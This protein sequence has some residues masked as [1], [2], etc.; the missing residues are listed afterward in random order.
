[1]NGKRQKKAL[2]VFLKF[3]EAGKVKTRLAAEIGPNEALRLY[4]ILARR[5]L[6]I[7]SDLIEARADID[8]IICY[9][10]P[11]KKQFIAQI[12]PGPWKFIAQKGETLGYR[13]RNAFEAAFGLG[14][15]QAVLMGTDI[16]DLDVG[17]LCEAFGA[18]GEG[19]TPVGPASDGGYYV[20]GLGRPCPEAFNLMSWSTSDVF[21]ETVTSLDKIGH[22]I[23]ILSERRD[24]DRLDD[25][26]FLLAKEFARDK[27]SIIIPFLESNSFQAITLA[28][29]LQ[30]LIWPDDEIILVKGLD[31]L[32]RNTECLHLNEKIRIICAPRG[33]GIQLNQGA[34]QASGTIL[35]F[36]HA[37]SVPPPNF[38]YH[39][40]KLTIGSRYSLGCFG[41][42]FKEV[43]PQLR[44]I[45][46]WANLR[47]RYL[48]LPYG[49]QGLFCRSRLFNLLGGFKKRLIMEDVEMAK[50]FRKSGKLLFISEKIVT[51]GRRYLKGGFFRRG[52]MNHLTMIMYL[53]GARDETLYRFYYGNSL[54]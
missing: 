35:W 20:I 5:S 24:V 2:L 39:I 41:L 43:P 22:R 28:E 18:L 3:P 36:L 53:A 14:Y 7:A 45:S 16:A 6:G 13:M 49:D 15:G 9:D 34:S 19:K 47:T 1:M 52:L 42:A 11:D 50:A 46:G 33:R 21:Q 26:E 8:G 54:I 4:S 31:D 17:D 10:P 12:Y 32:Y 37:D 48:G 38:G 27:I 30:D 44:L 40:R 51:S 25:A 23:A 29:R